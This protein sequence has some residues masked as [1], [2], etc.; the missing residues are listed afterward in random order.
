MRWHYASALAAVQAH[1]DEAGAGPL[2]E[3][4]QAVDDMIADVA[5]RAGNVRAGYVYVLSNLGAFGEH[6]ITIGMTRR[7]DPMNRVR[8]LGDGSVPFGFDVHAMFFADDAA[9]IEAQ[10][11]ARFAARRVNRVDQRRE[12]FYATPAEAKQHLMDL[13]GNL[14]RYEETALAVEFRQSR[15]ASSLSG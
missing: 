2:R 8:E 11:H 4:L 6:M 3:R 10:M 1:G 5:Y 13:T 14:L 12:F 7:L 15:P 9:G